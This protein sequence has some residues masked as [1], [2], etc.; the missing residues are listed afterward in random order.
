MLSPILIYVD[1]NKQTT[2]DAIIFFFD[3]KIEALLNISFFFLT[4]EVTAAS[5]ALFISVNSA[6]QLTNTL[7][8]C[9]YAGQ[10][11][12]TLGSYP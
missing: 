9:C 5:V 4:F 10:G 12:E 7:A 2:V 11:Y 6:H 8:T 1:I 3:V